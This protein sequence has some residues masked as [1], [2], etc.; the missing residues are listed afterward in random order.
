MPA[1]E[2]VAFVGQLEAADIDVWLDGGWGVDA[3]LEEQ[4]RPHDDLDLVV[5]LEDV[6]ELESVLARLGYER[7]GGD[8]PMSFESVDDGG[9]QVDTHPVRFDAEGNGVY[10]MRDGRTWLYPAGGFAG[11][12][13]VAGWRV[14]CLAPEVQV[15]SHAGYELDENDLADLKAL[16][17]RFAV[18]EHRD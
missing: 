3:L 4:T 13:S 9:R 14:R 10:R 1:H 2:V 7:A 12:G 8:P 15:I 11:E 17:E 16:R 6:P 5:A 18:D